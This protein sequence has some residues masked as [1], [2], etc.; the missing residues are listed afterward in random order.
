VLVVRDGERERLI[1]YV[2]EVVVR[3]VDL[4]AGRIEVDWDPAWDSD[5]PTERGP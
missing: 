4:A 1:P 3:R 5:T 2:P